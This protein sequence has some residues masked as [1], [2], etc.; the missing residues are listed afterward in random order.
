MEKSKI[1][2]LCPEPAQQ[3]L[4]NPP[5]YAWYKE[6]VDQPQ[7]YLEMTTHIVALQ[8]TVAQS[9]TKKV[10]SGKAV[11]KRRRL[12]STCGKYNNQPFNQN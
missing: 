6:L 3:P 9:L 5:S 1:L 4:N 8:A 12:I 10:A 11:I 2:L 7:D